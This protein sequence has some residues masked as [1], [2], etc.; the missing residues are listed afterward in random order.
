MFA[1]AG[2]AVV[3]VDI[4]EGALRAETEELTAAGHQAIGILCDVVDEVQAATMVQRPVGVVWTAGARLPFK[5][6]VFR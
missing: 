5:P 6:S 2:A 4:N 3:L 1:E